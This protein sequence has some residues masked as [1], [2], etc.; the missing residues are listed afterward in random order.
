MEEMTANIN[1]LTTDGGLIV[2][3]TDFK[4][5]RRN[6]TRLTKEVMNIVKSKDNKLYNILDKMFTSITEYHNK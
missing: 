3:D 1:Q 6:W 2:N 4:T 5:I